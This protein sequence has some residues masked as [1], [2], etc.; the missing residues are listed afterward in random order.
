VKKSKCFLTIM[1]LLQLLLFTSACSSAVQHLR[2][3]YVITLEG[4]IQELYHP[5]DTMSL[6]FG[7]EL[8]KDTSETPISIRVIAQVIG[9][10]SQGASMSALEQDM[11]TSPRV[12]SSSVVASMQLVTDDGVPTE[13]TRTLTLPRNMKAGYYEFLET[14]RYGD[15][16]TAGGG[17]I[18]IL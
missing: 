13:Y 5:G 7:R 17:I 18:H 9:P 3:A 4:P 10:F 6:K 8:R 14:S 16:T 1:F 15:T 11:Q 2:S 12:V